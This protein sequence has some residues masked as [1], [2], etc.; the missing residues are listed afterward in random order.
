MWCKKFRTNISKTRIVSQSF[1]WFGK[2]LYANY[3]SCKTGVFVRPKTFNVDSKIDY[4]I[5]K[6]TGFAKL[7]KRNVNAEYV[8]NFGSCCSIKQKT[9]LVKEAIKHSA[10]KF[11]NYYTTFFDCSVYTKY[12]L[13]NCNTIFLRLYGDDF[14]PANPVGSR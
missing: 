10:P 12:P 8:S 4:A 5:D 6:F 11:S 14:K 1:C 2:P 13:N 9:N 3:I 7:L